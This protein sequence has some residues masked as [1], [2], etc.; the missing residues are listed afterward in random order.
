MPIEYNSQTFNKRIRLNAYR[1][2]KIAKMAAQPAPI[3][4]KTVRN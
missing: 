3:K 1:S 4:A 2:D